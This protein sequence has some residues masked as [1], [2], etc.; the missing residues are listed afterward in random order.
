[1]VEARSRTHEQ[2]LEA[3]Q[4]PIE[5]GP[6]EAANKLI[7][8]ALSESAE[9]TAYLESER[10]SVMYEGEAGRERR[11]VIVPALFAVKGVGA[12]LAHYMLGP[13]D[14]PERIGVVTR[15][16]EELRMR[17]KV[18]LTRVHAAALHAYLETKSK[19]AGES[20]DHYRKLAHQSQ[21]N[22]R[23]ARALESAAAP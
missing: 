6:R 19:E 3:R 22:R 12:E 7:V 1:M 8:D 20:P 5:P 16:V 9:Y 11:E 15:D 14:D 2:G 10:V 13:E 18:E 4:R 17:A 21:P 23:H